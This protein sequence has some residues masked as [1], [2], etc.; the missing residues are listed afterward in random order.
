MLEEGRL[1]KQER[2]V[3]GNQRDLSLTTQQR[4]KA[5][6][7]IK[8][9]ELVEGLGALEEGV[10]DVAHVLDDVEGGGEGGVVEVVGVDDEVAG[11]LGEGAVE[12]LVEDHLGEFL[13]DLARREVDESGDVVDL[14]GGKGFDDFGE[15]ALEDVVVEL[16]EVVADEE[17]VVELR[18]KLPRGV[19]E[20]VQRPFPRRFGDGGHRLEVGPGVL[21]AV[22]GVDGAHHHRLFLFGHLRREVV[23][24]DLAQQHVLQALGG[25]FR[26]I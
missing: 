19:L 21:D 17:V 5:T 22:L 12:F 1:S 3:D 16:V 9:E 4:R 26:L 11:A 23:V 8:L 13:F 10:D 2:R 14:D 15:I 6:S 24:Q 7:F 25:A 18:R 20:F